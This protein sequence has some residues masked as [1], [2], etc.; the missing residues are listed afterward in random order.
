MLGYCWDDNYK[1]Q[2]E[3]DNKSESVEQVR[4]N[5]SYF[6]HNI[7]DMGVVRKWQLDLWQISL[8]QTRYQP[9]IPTKCHLSQC[10]DTQTKMTGGTPEVRFDKSLSL[11]T[12]VI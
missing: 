2:N 11:A 9:S 4:A 3:W 6:N 8:F 12:V 5:V 7:F 1:S 10:N